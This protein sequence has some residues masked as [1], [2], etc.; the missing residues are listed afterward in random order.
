MAL[1]SPGVEFDIARAVECRDVTP[2]ERIMQYP[3][4]RLIEVAL[5]VSVRFNE[6]SHDDVDEVNIEVSGAA[7]GLRVQDFAPATQLASEFTREIETTTT[8][9]KARSLEATL[10]GTLPVPG[11][12]AA[13]H[14]TP[15]ITGGLAGCETATEKINRLPPKHVVVVSGTYAEGRGVFFK[16]KRTNQTSLEGVHELAVT[17][18]APRSWPAVS[19]QVECSALGEKKTLWM[20]QTA[21]LGHIDRY[22]QLMPATMGPINQ[23]VLKP[24]DENPTIEEPA[25]LAANA[26]SP[27]KWRPARPTIGATKPTDKPATAPAAV[28]TKPPAAPFSDVKAARV[29]MATPDPVQN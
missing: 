22:V 12:E 20:K 6:L 7:A 9:K 8:N 23:T 2:R 29:E 19:L 1:A 16:L 14:L 15:S 28:A 5:P 27:S 17:F 24:T 21:T 26:A 25:V 11:A 3:T 10:G 13:A 4:Q 18:V